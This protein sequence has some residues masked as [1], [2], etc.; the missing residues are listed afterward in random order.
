MRTG[1]VSRAPFTEEASRASACSF[2]P[3][4]GVA[5][6]FCLD[7][8]VNLLAVDGDCPGASEVAAA[9][10]RA[11]SCLDGAGVQFLLGWHRLP[12]AM[13]AGRKTKPHSAAVADDAGN[14]LTGPARMSHRPQHP[15]R[16]CDACQRQILGGRGKW[17][18]FRVRRATASGRESKDGLP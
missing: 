7:G 10:C 5:R 13:G 18:E 2:A 9:M 4:D 14:A 15:M 11:I 12:F 16:G 6:A 1:I 8:L 17:L 3:P